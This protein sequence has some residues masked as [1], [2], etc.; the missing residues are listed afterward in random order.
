M[1]EEIGQIMAEDDDVT[2]VLV[3]TLT[4]TEYEFAINSVTGMII[5][6]RPLGLATKQV[7]VNSN[8]PNR[9]I[10]WILCIGA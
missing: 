10:V 6:A 1:G 7:W 5:V 2:S 8:I 9:L 3:Y 4:G